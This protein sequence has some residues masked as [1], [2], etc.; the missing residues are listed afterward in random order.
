MVGLRDRTAIGRNL[1]DD[2]LAQR[3]GDYPT[4]TRRVAGQIPEVDV[5][6]FDGIGHLPHIEAP[7]RFLAALG[8]VIKP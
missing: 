8:G 7:K 4:L 6:T 3:M 1:V 5:I 2:S